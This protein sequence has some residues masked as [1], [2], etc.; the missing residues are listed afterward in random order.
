[1]KIVIDTNWLISYLI[2]TE[3][4]NLKLLLTDTS[5]SF[6]TDEKQIKEFLEKIY[7]PRFRK[8]FEVELALEFIKNFTKRADLIQVSS[9]INVCRDPKDNFLL[10]LAKDSKADFLITGDKDLLVIGQF[11]QTII[12]TLCSINLFSQ[13]VNIIPKPVEMKV[14]NGNFILSDKTVFLENKDA[15][16]SISFFNDYLY[17]FYGFQLKTVKNAKENY[18][19]LS[20][21][22]ARK[23]IS[24][25]G[26]IFNSDC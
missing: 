13:E 19:R 25:E 5:A 3:T 4:S 26:Y 10:A 11:E 14:S 24:S 9:E 8:Y 16:H 22:A 17:R 21:I 23:P 6:I 7:L 20:V 15:N 1:M 18:I 12:C 2:K